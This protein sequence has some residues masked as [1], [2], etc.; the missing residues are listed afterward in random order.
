[1]PETCGNCLFCGD[2][3]LRGGSKFEVLCLLHI[4][5][6]HEDDYKCDNYIKHAVMPESERLKIAA[7]LRSNSESQKKHQETVEVA[8]EANKI[9]KEANDISRSAKSAA[10]WAIWISIGSLI[11]SI[12]VAIFKK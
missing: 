12:S 7:E 6:W 5:K 8:K 10:W 4:G 2:H 3:K 9:S 1:M 11:V